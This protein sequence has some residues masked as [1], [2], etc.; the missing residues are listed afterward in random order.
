M[1]LKI[2]EG[3]KAKNLEH[4]ILPLLS[5]D[6]Y[7]SKI[8]DR[9]VI[10]VGFFVF[11]KD[12]AV[13]LSNFIDKSTSKVLDTEVSPAPTSEGY[14]VLFVEI[15]RNEEFPKLLTT[16]LSEVSNLCEIKK[17]QMQ[18]PWHTEPTDISLESLQENLI[19][20][21][22]EIPEDKKDDN[23]KKI[24]KKSK[25]KKRKSK[26]SE[27]IDFW[28]HS[29]VDNIALHDENITFIKNNQLST[30]AV[31]DDIPISNIDLL[32]TWHTNKLQSLLGPNYSVWSMQNCLVVEHQDTVKVLKLIS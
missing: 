15:L 26:V 27:D 30:Y 16:I 5:I 18:S 7:E 22:E 13:D 31:T 14:Y 32:E 9:R 4:L 24:K 29:Q 20:N 19:L 10:V 21:P 28:L 3:L 6:E 25:K 12:P 1:P 8:D 11:D 23:G 17:W 2:I